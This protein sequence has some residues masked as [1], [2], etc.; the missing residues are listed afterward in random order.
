[1]EMCNLIYMAQFKENIIDKGHNDIL[2]TFNKRHEKLIN[3]NLMIML[4][5]IDFSSSHSVSMLKITILSF[6]NPEL[7]IKFI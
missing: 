3:L 5:V 2:L 1:M 6:K 4:S 7:V